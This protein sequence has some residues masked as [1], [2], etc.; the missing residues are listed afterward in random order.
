VDEN[1]DGCVDWDEFL[2]MFNRNVNDQTG[3]EPSKLYNMVS[4]TK[5]K[6]HTSCRVGCCERLCDVPWDSLAYR[7]VS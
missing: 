6:L 3:L 2:L 5:Q 1:L 7:T 4:K